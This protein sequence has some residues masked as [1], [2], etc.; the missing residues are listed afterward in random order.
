MEQ[1]M[2]TSQKLYETMVE[3]G[4]ISKK[5]WQMEKGEKTSGR[6]LSIKQQR[7]YGSSITEVHQVVISRAPL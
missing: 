6:Q 2:A 7:V 4:E 1:P 5:M 3:R